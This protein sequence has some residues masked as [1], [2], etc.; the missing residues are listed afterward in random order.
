M[1]E[2]TRNLR[3]LY[4]VTQSCFGLL[5]FQEEQRSCGIYLLKVTV[6]TAFAH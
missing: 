3:S 2:F 4:Q 5:C 6:T 1:K